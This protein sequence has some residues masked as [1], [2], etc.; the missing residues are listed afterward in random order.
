MERT[1]VTRSTAVVTPEGTEN[2]PGTDG[3]ERP[4]VV[5]AG[6]PVLEEIR[7]HAAAVDCEPVYVPDLDTALPY[8]Q[9][10]PLVL[11]DDDV[12]PAAPGMPRRDD[13]FLLCGGKPPQ[14][15]WRRAFALGA[16]EVVSLP[17]SEGVLLAVLADLAEAPSTDRGRVVA[18]IGGRGGAGASVVA[19]AVSVSAARSG[20]RS[21]L[22]DC[23]PLGGGI[24][25]VLGAESAEGLRWPDVRVQG[26]RL[27][28]SA[29]DEALPVSAHG[30]GHVALLSCG[31][32]GADP[33]PEAVA[34]VVEAG[35]RAGR[36]VV[37]DL[38][39]EPGPCG[40]R[41]LRS[42]DLVVLVVPAELRASVAASRVLDRLGEARSRTRV[43]VRGPAPDGLAAHE[44]AAAVGAPSLGWLH[45]DR[46]LAKAV[47][48]GAFAPSR[49]SP[50]GTAA[51]TILRAL[52]AV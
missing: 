37:C 26:G 52:R 3:G 50:L 45:A 17:D 44:V 13:V 6:G 10:A 23:D 21:V 39:R 20:T 32:D 15:L 36:I 7:R 29:L 34:A 43:L 30:D 33:G 31:R 14:S 24:D 40:R 8:W 9:D 48:R 41:V 16:R 35:V 38:P 25:L 5:S 18:V 28:M 49:R 22:V 12:V 1:A 27:A 42:A 2:E 4:L 47:E 46:R 11:V 19:A 51:T